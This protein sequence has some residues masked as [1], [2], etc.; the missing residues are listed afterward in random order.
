ML[1][2]KASDLKLWAG[3]GRNV[4]MVGAIRGSTYGGSSGLLLEV[5]GMWRIRG[6]IL[7]FIVVVIIV[8]TA[9]RV[10]GIAGWWVCGIGVAAIVAV[11]FFVAIIV[12]TIVVGVRVGVRVRVGVVVGQIAIE[13]AA[14]I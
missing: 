7:A 13:V 14:I 12:V 8:I 9:G 10:R 5:A 3:A 2:L 11:G 6:D 1:P 4:A